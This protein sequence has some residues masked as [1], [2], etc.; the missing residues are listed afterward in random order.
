VSRLL[1]RIGNG[2]VFE[3]FKSEKVR[4]QFKENLLWGVGWALF[5]SLWGANFLSVFVGVF[6][7]CFL[8]DWVK[9]RLK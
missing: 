3:M 5:W 7:G 4:K 2:K 8:V 6:V 9:G 1:R